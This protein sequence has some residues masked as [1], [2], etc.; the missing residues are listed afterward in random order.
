MYRWILSKALLGL[1]FS[2]SIMATAQP[3]V[4][5]STLFQQ[6]VS[7]MELEQFSEAC[8]LLE[9]SY[10][11]D[12]KAGTLFTLANCRDREGK[13]SSASARYGE[14]LR[15][16]ANMTATDRQKHAARAKMAETRAAELQPQLPTLQLK[17]QGELPAHVK[18][19][20]DDVDWTVRSMTLPLPLDPGPHEIIVK[21]SG[22]PDF[23]RV[24]TLVVGQI[25]TFDLNTEITFVKPPKSE[26]TIAISPMKMVP[27][28]GK[29]GTNPRKTAGFITLGVGGA[30]LVFG[31]VMGLL[32][33]AE[34]QTVKTFCTGPNGY[35]CDTTG[36][37]A[38]EKMRGYAGP[39]TVGFVAAGVL[40]ATGAVLVM[41]APARSKEKPTSMNLRASGVWGGW[42]VGVEGS[43]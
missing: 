2:W 41:T 42:F 28:S 26:S 25:K 34:K 10:R 43:F 24:V 5:A 20:V 35:D 23:K 9:E 14:Y 39:S 36:F 21:Q 3:A 22:A 17:W 19:F 6:A 8:P 1:I 4:V 37:S 40:T 12:A 32:A 11:L 27:P 38:V 7:K 13:V 30:S 33:V 31:S 15:A 16:H 18:I 29:F